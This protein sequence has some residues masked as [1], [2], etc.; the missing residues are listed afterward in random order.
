MTTDRFNTFNDAFDVLDLRAHFSFKT[1][2]SV[3]FHL[4]PVPRGPVLRTVSGA[5]QVHHPCDGHIQTQ[6]Y[7]QLPRRYAEPLRLRQF[8]EVLFAEL[9]IPVD[10]TFELHFNDA[11]EGLSI[12]Q[13]VNREGYVDAI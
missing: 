2:A 4:G 3:G 11:S 7:V 10:E 8:R 13:R 9:G 12:S 1:A 6:V 5:V